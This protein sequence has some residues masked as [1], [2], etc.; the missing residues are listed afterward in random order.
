MGSSSADRRPGSVTER[1]VVDRP[2][3]GSARRVRTR[4]PRRRRRP[5]VF[6]RA[7]RRAVGVGRLA[8]A[9]CCPAGADLASLPVGLYGRGMNDRRGVR[10]SLRIVSALAMAGGRWDAAHTACLA[11]TPYQNVLPTP[12]QILVLVLLVQYRVFFSSFPQR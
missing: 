12:T 6:L 4:V 7:R 3:R 11:V 2:V 8:A 5:A 1:A 10:V 9:G